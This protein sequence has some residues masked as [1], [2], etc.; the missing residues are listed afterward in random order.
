M[1][2]DVLQLVR[3]AN[4][5]PVD[6]PAP[7]IERL[8]ERLDEAL[9]KSAL[10]PSPRRRW[11]TR[12]GALLAL[13][14]L[15]VAVPALAATQ[16]WQ[17]ILGRPSLHDTPAG[18]SSTPPPADQLQLLGILRRPQSDADR[19]PIAQK[20]LKSVGSEYKGV[21]LDSIRLL[22]A[23]NGQHALLVPAEQHGLSAQPGRYEE[24]NDLCIEDW[25]GGF[26]GTAEQVRDGY[27]MGDHGDNLLGL[28]PDG[29]A[30]VVLTFRNGETLTDQVQENF[31][32]ASGVPLQERTFRLIPH[33]KGMPKTLTHKEAEV[34]EVQW[35]DHHGKLVGPPRALTK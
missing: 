11:D 22:T 14:A 3:G 34:P 1:T 16:P 27:F 33:V 13:G 28:V 21:R 23:S 25:P 15:A 35:F 9:P 5:V 29:V 19:G 12:R 18:I 4:P 7:P 32:W 30:K 8:L 24:A 6:P 31:F 26:C 2:G 17:P 20:L 10:P